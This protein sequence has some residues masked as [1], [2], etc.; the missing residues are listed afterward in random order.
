[1]EQTLATGLTREGISAKETKL[2]ASLNN[3]LLSSSLSNE[4]KVRLLLI[5]ILT[6]EIPEKDRAKMLEA[7]PLE[8]KA[9]IP[10]LAWFGFKHEKK[11]KK[12]S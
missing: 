11:E 7:I 9:A 1:M 8:D 4:D 5:A 10:K 2:I 3:F 6:T 12:N